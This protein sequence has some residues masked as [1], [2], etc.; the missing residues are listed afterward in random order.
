VRPERQRGRRRRRDP[1]ATVFD[2]V[3]DEARAGRSPE[4]IGQIGFMPDLY[5]DT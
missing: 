2:G 5:L 1:A 4:S 3:R